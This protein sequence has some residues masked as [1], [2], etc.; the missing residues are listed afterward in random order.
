MI[1]VRPATSADTDAVQRIYA[2]SVGTA[3]WLPEHAHLAT[4]FGAVSVGEVVHVAATNSGEVLGFVSVQPDASFVHHLFVRADVQGQGIG[5]RLLASL[6]P[7]L[8]VPWRLKCVRANQPALAFYAELGWREVA[9]GE[10][11]HGPYAVLEWSGRTI[12]LSGQAP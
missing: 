11:E 7:W 1:D 3:E 8:P 2:A 5:R 9:S 4:D 6:E 12:H 10:S